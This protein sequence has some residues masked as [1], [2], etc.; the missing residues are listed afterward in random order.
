MSRALKENV[1][2]H[3]LFTQNLAHIQKVMGCSRILKK[4]ELFS[5]FRSYQ[6]REDDNALILQQ[7]Y[8]DLKKYKT[9]ATPEQIKDI[10]LYAR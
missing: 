5:S 6:K 2:R 8:L 10:F 9:T 7:S 4:D 3:V 1:I